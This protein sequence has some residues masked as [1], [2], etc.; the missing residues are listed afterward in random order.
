MAGTAS[1]PLARMRRLSALTLAIFCTACTGSVTEL[2]GGPLVIQGSDTEVQLVSSLAEAFGEGHPGGD[3]SVTGGG[4]AVGIAALI[5][6]NTDIAN[7]SRAMTEEER[8]QAAAAGVDVQEIVLARDGLTVVTHPSNPVAMLSLE[9][10]GKIYRGEITNWKDAGG[11]DGE[12]VLY[13]RQSTSGTYSYFRT[14]VLKADYAEGM[15]QMEGTQAIVDSVAADVHGIGYVGVGYLL[16][17]GGAQ[18]R[19]KAL[20]LSKEEGGAPVSSL[21][22]EAVLAGEY[23]LARPIYQY[24]NGR[25]AAESPVFAFVSFELSAEGQAVVEASGFYP[26]TEADARQNGTVLGQDE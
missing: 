1:F 16:E 14:T 9:T 17:E 4:S 25:P 23:P 20:P 7:S 10:L 12:I 13:G 24:V 18:D 3:I 21:D 19:V 6:G 8:A 22:K 11:T 15:R 26:V 2:S 5:N